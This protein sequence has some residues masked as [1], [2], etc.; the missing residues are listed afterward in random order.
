MKLKRILIATFLGVVAL[1]GSVA[2]VR[3]Q[4]PVVG[5][6]NRQLDATAGEQGA[7][8]GPA[9]DPRFIVI[10]VIRVL[11]T[12]VGIALIVLNVYAGY[13]WMTAGGNDEQIGQ[14]KT[15]IRNGVVGLIIVLASYSITIFAANLARGYFWYYNTPFNALFF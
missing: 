2:I 3:A 4:A 12:F 15:T 13:Q 7:G 11:L 10:F 8:F 1:L 9:S 5:E 14:A 6:I